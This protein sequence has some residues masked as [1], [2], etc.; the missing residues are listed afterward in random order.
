MNRCQFCGEPESE[1]TTIIPDFDTCHDCIS[2]LI[3]NEA[4]R[5]R[6]IAAQ[7]RPVIDLME[8]LRR[9]LKAEVARTGGVA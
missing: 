8:A 5:R 2:S 9:S 1:Q 4:E 3:D 6:S 7:K